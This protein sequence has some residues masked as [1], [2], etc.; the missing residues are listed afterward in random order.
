MCHS[1]RPK[2]V[3]NLGYIVRDRLLGAVEI[4]RRS[5]RALLRMTTEVVV[6]EKSLTRVYTD[7]KHTQELLLL[8]DDIVTQQQPY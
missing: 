2:G 5:L 1:E 4:L 3:K 6:L 7:S 8:G